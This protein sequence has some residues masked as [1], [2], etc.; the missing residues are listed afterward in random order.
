MNETSK[1][2]FPEAA[3]HF[4]VTIGVLRRAIRTGRLPAPPDL[5]ATANLPAEWFASAQAAVTAS[6]K[7]LS[8]STMQ[9][10]P[11][12]ARYEGTSAWRKYSNRVRDYA[13]F[14][15]TA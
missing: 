13:R 10:T 14:R 1:L 15:A 5:G 3:R 9:K 7:V 6:P 2:G 4:G 8:R 11:A 12:F